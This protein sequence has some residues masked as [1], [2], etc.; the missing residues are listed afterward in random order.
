M[1]KRRKQGYLVAAAS[2]SV[3]D[4]GTTP[5]V[6][7]GRQ[8]C[9]PL[10]TPSPAL[11]VKFRLQLPRQPWPRGMLQGTWRQDRRRKET[12]RDTHVCG[13]C[14]C[15]RAGTHPRWIQA[16]DPSVGVFLRAL[17]WLLSHLW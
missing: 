3:P 10:C 1:G 17:P 16:P 6:G 9:V 15:A 2:I 5:T 12:H 8:Y 13:V 11:V 4:P 14:L 7:V